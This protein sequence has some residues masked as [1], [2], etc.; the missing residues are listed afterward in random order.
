[1]ADQDLGGMPLHEAA[2][3]A[4]VQFHDDAVSS[5]GFVEANGLRFHYLEWGKPT[6]RPLVMLHG[7]GQTAHSWDFA[8]LALCDRYRIIALDQRGHGDSDWAPNA[9]YSLS[10]HQSDL[11]AVMTAL[12][13]DEIVLMG[14]SMGGRNAFTYAADHPAQVAT[15]IVVDSAPEL[16][17][18]GADTIRRFVEDMDVLD[19]FEE[20]VVKTKQYNPRRSDRQIRGSLANNLKQLPDGRW[21][22]KYDKI[23]RSSDAKPW[24]DPDIVARM[25]QKVEGV[26]CPTLIVRGAGST[27]LSQETA[28]EMAERLPNGRLAVVPDAG[29]LVPGDNPTGFHQ[30]VEAFLTD[31]PQ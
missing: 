28:E 25:W 3:A 10:D 8:A 17:R 29:H 26:Q 16:Q 18:S 20:F 6:D 21:T 2:R 14:L 19:T 7:M 11:A 30:V 15:L 22:W 5:S 1:M 12:G 9:E 27:V 4:G 24:T 31:I 23:F 13:L